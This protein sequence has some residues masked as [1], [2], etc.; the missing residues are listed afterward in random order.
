VSPSRAQ[1]PVSG[2]SRPRRDVPRSS[3]ART[4]SFSRPNPNGRPR[5]RHPDIRQVPRAAAV[6]FTGQHM[7]TATS[8]G[9][10][11]DPT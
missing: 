8:R 2:R 5:A 11:N 9:H 7:Q 6:P 4:V 3:G 10:E 1:R